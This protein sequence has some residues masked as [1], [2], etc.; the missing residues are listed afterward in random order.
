MRD[1]VL[2]LSWLP[3]TSELVRA[4]PPIHQGRTISDREIHQGSDKDKGMRV[5]FM[6][7]YLWGR[8]AKSII[9][10]KLVNADTGT[11]KYDPM[12][13]LLDLW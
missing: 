5:G 11:Y 6:I 7:W 10:V 9:D 2:Y 3:F 8:K 4:K 1:G 13:E 12:V